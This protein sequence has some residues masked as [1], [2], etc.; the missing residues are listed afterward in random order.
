MFCKMCGTEAGTNDHYCVKCGTQ[1][2]TGTAPPHNSDVNP[3]AQLQPEQHDQPQ[4]IQIA[5]KKKSPLKY[6]TTII[7]VLG[8]VMFI[9]ALKSWNWIPM[10]FFILAGAS[11]SYMV[12]GVI[13]PASFNNVFNRNAGDAKKVKF[14]SLHPLIWIP[15]LRGTVTRKKIIMFFGIIALIFFIFFIT[16]VVMVPKSEPVTGNTPVVVVTEPERTD[17]PNVPGPVEYEIISEDDISYASVKRKSYRIVVSLEITEEQ[18]EPTVNEIINTLTTADG[19][20]DEIHL[21]LYSDPDIVD[22]IYDVARAVWG[23]NGRLGDISYDAARSNDR[24]NHTT[25]ITIKQDLEEYLQQRSVHEEKFG[26]TEDERRQIFREAVA[27]E[28][29]GMTEAERMYPDPE[30]IMEQV[31]KIGELQEKYKAEVMEK[32]G[33]SEEV[34]LDI[35]VEGV[36]MHWPMN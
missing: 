14:D 12:L 31:Y 20:V 26:L 29:R 17:T 6:L 15:E 25:S 33:I 16:A 24:S 35:L 36:T 34:W 28:D 19:D 1:L 8:L 7:I 23:V 22:G 13:R 11:F 9:P 4:D 21:L 10:L 32:W 27:A 5:V 30:D 18:V 3:T 2:V